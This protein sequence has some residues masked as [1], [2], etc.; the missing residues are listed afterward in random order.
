MNHETANGAQRELSHG[1]RVAEAEIFM[2][3]FFGREESTREP[4][5]FLRD[6]RVQLAES[7]KAELRELLDAA[8]MLSYEVE[9]EQE[10][11]RS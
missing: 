5:E 1:T 10:R 4:G 6:L 3:A 7:T 9:R 8:T 2:S 11:R